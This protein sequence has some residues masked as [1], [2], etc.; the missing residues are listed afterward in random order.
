M[1]GATTSKKRKDN[2]AANL[3]RPPTA[4]EVARLRETENLF[5]SSLF[6]LQIEEMIGELSIKKKRLS[7]FSEW[8]SS[9]K[10]CLSKMKSGKQREVNKLLTDYSILFDECLLSFKNFVSK[11]FSFV[12]FQLMDQNW[13]AKLNMSIPL[14]QEPF[15][16]KGNFNFLPPLSISIVGSHAIDCSLGPNL[17]VDVA[18][19]MPSVCVQHLFIYTFLK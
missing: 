17:N 7:S 8:F 13:L 3:K 14:V 12:Y 11:M 10:Q 9:F 2:K 1:E 16:V 6:R 4:Q 15:S 18:I 19:E 5:H